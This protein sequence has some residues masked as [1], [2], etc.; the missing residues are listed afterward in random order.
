MKK[1]KTLT[2]AGLLALLTACGGTKTTATDSQTTNRG[3]ANTEISDKSPNA[4]ASR[5]TTTG[6]RTVAPTISKSET[7][8]AEIAYN[9][10]LQ[11]MYTDLNMSDDQIGS[12][13]K[14]WK[15]KVTAWKTSNRTK[16]MNNFER[17]EYQDRILKDVLNETQFKQY[18]Q[19]A[20]DN[21]GTVEE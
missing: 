13:E 16:T 8:N 15:T 17:T 19:W 12:F 21:A 10:K 1:L 5:Q 11:K 3:R 18:Q 14:E 20:R 2:A 9:A 6:T 7:E 4:T